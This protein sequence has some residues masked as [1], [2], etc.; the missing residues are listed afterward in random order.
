[1][2]KLRPKF[3]LEQFTQQTAKKEYLLS[4]SINNAK[5]VLVM[6]TVVYYM[7]PKKQVI[8]VKLLNNFSKNKPYDTRGFKEKV[9]IKY[10]S[11]KAMARKFPNG[12]A[13]IMA[14][15]ATN[16]PPLDWFA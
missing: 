10:D 12:T 8:A 9:K 11:V 4:S 5:F 16:E 15:L 13:V 1:M 7:C 2:K 3:L 14:L 6:M